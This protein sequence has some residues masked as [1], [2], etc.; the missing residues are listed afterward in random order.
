MN[1]EIVPQG[2]DEQFDG[3]RLQFTGEGFESIIDLDLDQERTLMHQLIE[4]AQQRGEHL[5]L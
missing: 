5:T 4:R 1:I 2:E 3:P